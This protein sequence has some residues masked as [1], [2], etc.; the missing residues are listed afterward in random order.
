MIKPQQDDEAIKLVHAVAGKSGTESLQTITGHQTIETASVPETFALYQN[1]PNPF[2]M[3]TMIIYDIPNT[4]KNAVEVKLSIYNIQGQLVK[5]LEDR[6]RT[7]GKYTVHWN[8]TDESGLMVSSG[9][10]YYK[11]IAND[12]VLT[13]KLAI[14]K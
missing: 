11:L 13:K 2:N 9:V 7:A 6:V 12:V 8:G 1:T 14:M 4:V 3:S 10:Y 5:T